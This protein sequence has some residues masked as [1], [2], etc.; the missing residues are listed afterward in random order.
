MREAA[1]H[2]LDDLLPARRWLSP[3]E[4]HGQ[5]ERSMPAAQ[6]SIGRPCPRKCL[7]PPECDLAPCDTELGGPDG[8][9]SHAQRLKD[10]PGLFPSG[11]ELV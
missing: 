11:K 5:N 9:D 3:V 1:G 7:S 10:L 8:I 6:I 4:R 2:R